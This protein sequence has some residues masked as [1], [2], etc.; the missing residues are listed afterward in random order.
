[1]KRFGR[2]SLKKFSREEKIHFC[3]NIGIGIA[4]VI[5]LQFFENTDFGE[6]ALNKAFDYIIAKE[7]AEAAASGNI[8]MQ[9]DKR[10]AERVAFVDMGK[11]YKK[12]GSPLITPRDELAK[13]IEAAYKGKAKVIV[14]DILLED[15]DCCH[16]E[17]DRKLREVFKNMIDQNASTKVI[18]PVRIASEGSI[19]KNLFEDLFDHHPNF[20]PAIPYIS[21]TASDRVVR[22]WVPYETIKDHGRYPL[23]WNASFLAA[24]LAHGKEEELKRIGQKM[25]DQKVPEAHIIELSNKKEI[26]ISPRREDLYRNRVR[27]FLIPENTVSK[28]PGGN[29]FELVS[30]VDEV[31]YVA[32][33]DKV[34]IIGNGNPEAGD[35]HLTPVGSMP[36]MYIIGNATN[37]ILLGLQP[38]H[39]SRVLNIL[40]ELA[41]IIIAAYILSRF[42]PLIIKVLKGVVLISA[43][44]AIS[45]YYFLKTGV[46]L[47]VTF[48]VVG[49]G[50]HDMAMS[51]EKV[52][53]KRKKGVKEEGP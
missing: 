46:L 4:V 6:H 50:F 17:H 33:K 31:D 42:P 47:N 19:K 35:I 22:Y 23:L 48:A 10:V 14:L 5:L 32:F 21:A 25:N 28:H 43:L 51:V 7:A 52:L 38:A 2:P 36:G 53:I 13:V 11:T 15:K 40:I 24:V 1:M 44:G 8:V 34:V 18:F 49:M 26:E 3:I 37:T 39:P 27:F 30:D 20:Y 12:R 45:Y 41:V 9:K 29:L 16:P